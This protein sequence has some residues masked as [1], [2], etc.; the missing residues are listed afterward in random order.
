MM[1][2]S[3]IMPMSLVYRYRHQQSILTTAIDE[4]QGVLRSRV[5]RESRDRV[6]RRLREWHAELFYLELSLAERLAEL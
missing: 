5:T 6:T 2:M 1:P 4:L 3:A